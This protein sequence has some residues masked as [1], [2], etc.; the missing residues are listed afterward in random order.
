[1]ARYARAFRIKGAI[2]RRVVDRVPRQ[3]QWI[4]T[5]TS[6][7]KTVDSNCEVGVLVTSSGNTIT[8]TTSASCAVG[9][10]TRSLPTANPSAVSVVEVGVH[11]RSAPTANPSATSVAF[12]GIQPSCAGALQGYVSTSQVAIGVVAQSG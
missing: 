9:V 4:G 5:L 2:Y 12:V 10:Q 6:P 11:A 7:N 3:N 1:M 8:V